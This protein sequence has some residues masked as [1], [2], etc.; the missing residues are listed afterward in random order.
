M[1]GVQNDRL[2]KVMKLACRRFFLLYTDQV[3][4]RNRRPLNLLSAA[5]TFMGS[6][7]G[8][9]IQ[10]SYARLIAIPPLQ[11]ICHD[12]H[13]QG[14]LSDRLFYSDTPPSCLDS[15][16][17]IDHCL[18]CLFLR[19]RAT[20]TYGRLEWPCSLL[21][22]YSYAIAKRSVAF[23]HESSRRQGLGRQAQGLSGF[24]FRFADSVPKGYSLSQEVDSQRPWPF[25]LGVR[26]MGELNA[27]SI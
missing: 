25:R 5:E 20:R 4:T 27:L 9:W 13:G 10:F 2:K 26:T 6:S 7:N 12:N 21:D 22:F 11:W 14:V 15:F 8:S 24:L 1:A 19:G 17:V 16:L 23:K 18:T 3:P